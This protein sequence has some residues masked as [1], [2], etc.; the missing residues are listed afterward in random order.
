MKENKI[1]QNEVIKQGIKN[2]YDT[3]QQRHQGGKMFFKQK[4]RLVF[5][6]TKKGQTYTDNN[7]K[8]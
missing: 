7:L 2:F 3:S 5:F 6:F 8:F 1:K 4:G